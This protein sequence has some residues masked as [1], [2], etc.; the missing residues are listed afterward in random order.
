MQ[1]KE[2]APSEEFVVA[3]L[4]DYPE[5]TDKKRKLTKHGQNWSRNLE[6]PECPTLGTERVKWPV[7]DVSAQ[8]DISE[9][10][11]VFSSER[12][13]KCLYRYKK[14]RIVS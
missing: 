2:S 11:V 4:G 10:K 9:L 8:G 12:D 5:S 13:G 14:G 1:S 6:K 3:V 7:A